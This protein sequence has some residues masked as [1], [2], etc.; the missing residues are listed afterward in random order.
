[1]DPREVV[2]PGMIVRS[3]TA[4]RMGHVAVVRDDGFDLADGPTVRWDE[5]IEVKDD[6]VWVSAHR[7]ALG[8]RAQG[9]PRW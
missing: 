2:R 1:M 4:K 8:E 9:S 7:H 5:V 3:G 6:E